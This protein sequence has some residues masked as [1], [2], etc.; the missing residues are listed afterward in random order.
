MDNYS[1]K[2]R[3][4]FLRLTG[5]ATTLGD[6]FT[7]STFTGR[8]VQHMYFEAKTSL[9][10]TPSKN[11]EEAGMT[12]LNN[13]THFDLVVK[14]SG[15]KRVLF[16]RLQFE[17]VIHE[18]E[19]FSLK[20]GPVTLKVEGHKSNFSFSF[21]QGDEPFK[22]VQKVSA[23]YL[24][25]ETIGGFTGTYVGLYATGNGEPSEAHADFDWFEYVET[26]GE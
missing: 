15:N 24:S 3:P 26:D 14:N 9:D 12:L 22:E 20:P 8:R 7:T 19:E 21:S 16:A 1:L 17:N 5:A 11:N 4:G 25:S 18:S 23:R 10:F 2:E 6:N 13:G